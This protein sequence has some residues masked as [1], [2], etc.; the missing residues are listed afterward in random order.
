MNIRDWPMNKIMSLPDH[1]FG[2][3]FVV[4]LMLRT[5]EEATSWDISEL[6]LPER[7]VLWEFQMGFIARDTG[8]ATVRL[9]FGDQLPT[10]TA[11]MDI[12]EP[13]LPGFGYQG[14]DPR[15]ILV[16]GTMLYTLQKVKVPV[17]TSGRRI[18]MEVTSAA[19]ASSAVF[20]LFVFSSMPTEIPDWLNYHT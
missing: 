5:I 18:I 11:Q 7:C 6:A 1:C 16:R 12:L 20:G 13:V 9:A 2:R 15:T 4:G 3:R 8:I 17:C 19:V 14:A 10:T